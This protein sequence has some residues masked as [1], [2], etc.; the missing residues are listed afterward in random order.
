M[1]DS[2]CR[3]AFGMVRFGFVYIKVANQGGLSPYP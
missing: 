3:S 2:A 1:A